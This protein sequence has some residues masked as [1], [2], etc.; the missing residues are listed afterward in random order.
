MFRHPFF[1]DLSF[2]SS[3]DLLKISP[4]PKRR[5]KTGLNKKKNKLVEKLFDGVFE[6]KF[7]FSR[8][9]SGSPKILA[10]LS[11]LV[12]KFCEREEREREKRERKKREKD[13][14]WILVWGC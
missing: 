14:Q 5:T 9:K 6:Q 8:C 11:F 4:L 7:I 3:H 12:L 2:F 1:P 10:L 13:H